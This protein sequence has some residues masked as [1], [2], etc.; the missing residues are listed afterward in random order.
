MRN[1]AAKVPEDVSPEVK[2]RVQAV[3][4]A[5]GRAIA[6]DLAKG[7]V[8]DDGRDVPPAVARFEVDF[9]ACIAHLRMPV[10]HRRA[11]RTTPLLERLFAKER[12]RLK[13]LPDAVG[14]RPV[15]KPVFGAVTRAAGPRPSAGSSTPNTRPP[16]SPRPPSPGP[17][18]AGFPAG[19][20][21]HPVSHGT[22]RKRHLPALTVEE[23][24]PPGCRPVAAPREARR[25]A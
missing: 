23:S 16:T 9:E 10:T 15:L 4:Q 3:C 11:I 22:R 13:T 21:L 20:G 19:L 1:L 7:V 18:P 2:A 17:P 25:H 12:R 5:P 14:A 24:G 6:R 8:E